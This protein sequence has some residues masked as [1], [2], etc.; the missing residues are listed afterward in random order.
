MQTVL[1]VSRSTTQK[2]VENLQNLLSFSKIQT[3]NSVK[4]ILSK[5]KIEVNDY[6]LQ[7]I[8]S[9][10]ALTNLGER[11]SIYRSQREYIF[12]RALSYYQTHR[13]SVQHSPQKLFCIYI[14]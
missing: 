9:A 13:I 11:F 2:I 6:V 10:I 8:S 5:H 14:C 7:E 12:Q 1:H 3:F 4:E